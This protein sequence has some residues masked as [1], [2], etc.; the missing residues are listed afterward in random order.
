MSYGAES[1]KKLQL[2]VEDAI[3]QTIKIVLPKWRKYV[4]LGI[5]GNTSDGADCIFPAV[6]Y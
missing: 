2:R 1:K 5:N 4:C 3:N 6:R